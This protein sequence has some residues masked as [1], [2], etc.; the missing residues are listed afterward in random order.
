MNIKEINII[1]LGFVG[2][3]TAVGFAYKGFKVNAIE[4]DKKKTNLLKKNKLYFNEPKLK[5]KYLNVKKKGLIFIKNKFELTDTK[6]YPNH[7]DKKTNIIFICIGTPINKNG[8]YDLSKIKSFLTSL[9]RYKNNKFLVVIKSTFL[10]GTI[11]DIF[12]KFTNDN[13]SFCSNPEFLREGFAWNDFIK[14]DRIVIGCNDNKTKII[15]NNIYKKFNCIKIYTN[16]NTAEF[17]KIASNNFL[18]NTI[19]FANNI[20]L[21]A[22]KIDEVDIKLC[23]DALHKDSR[24]YGNPANMAG[25][26]HPGIGY[27]G[28]CLPKD[29]TAFNFLSKRLFKNN[30]YIAENIKINN[31][32]KNFYAKKI[33]KLSKPFKKICLLGLSFKHL[34]DDI[35]ESKAI[36]L[37]QELRKYKKEI[38]CFDPIIKFIDTKVKYKIYNEPIFNKNYF[39]VLTVQWDN[40]IKFLKKIPKENFFDTRYIV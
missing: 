7:K 32:L 24:W 5:E 25:Y 28:Y 31:Y 21:I 27:G 26:L 23:F 15:L 10:P 11:K 37:L 20:S 8:N 39:Y 17:I 38:I 30:F 22:H 4:V 13:I 33:I 2:L 12:K 3:T 6:K 34:S 29:T 18:S 35:R 40:Y 14:P 16:T 9:K 1:G 19:S 36:E